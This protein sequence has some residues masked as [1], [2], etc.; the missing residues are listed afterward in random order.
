MRKR[1]VVRCEQVIDEDLRLSDRDE[2]LVVKNF[3]TRGSVE[4]FGVSVLPERT[5]VDA[6]WLDAD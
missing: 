2:S 3:R 4:P 1:V 6:D 5:W